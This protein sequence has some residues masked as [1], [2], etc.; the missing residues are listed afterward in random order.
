[1]R[2]LEI[3]FEKVYHEELPALIYLN[4]FFE[5]ENPRE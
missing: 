4:I 5:I 2:E 3:I 1:M